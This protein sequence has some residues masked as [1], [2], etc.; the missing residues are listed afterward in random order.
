MFLLAGFYCN[1]RPIA[2]IFHGG[3][4]VYIKNRDQLI[5]V[6]MAGHTIA[7]DTRLLGRSGA[8]LPRK[9]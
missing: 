3:G 6:G 4:G 7:E 5:N 1:G 2:R 8:F 9:F